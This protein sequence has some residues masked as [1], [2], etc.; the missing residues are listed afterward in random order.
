MPFSQAACALAIFLPHLARK[1]YP[2]AARGGSA[3]QV[4]I[5]TD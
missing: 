1:V 2:F 5:K 4:A 3:N